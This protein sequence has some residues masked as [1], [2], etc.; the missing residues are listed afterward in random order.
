MVEVPQGFDLG[1]NSGLSY[2]YCTSREISIAQAMSDAQIHPRFLGK[3]M[4]TM[5][6][7]P[8]RVGGT[9]GP[10]YSDSDEITWEELGVTP[11]L[12]T[13]TKRVRR[14]ATFS[15]LQYERSLNAIVPDYVFLNFLNYIPPASQQIFINRLTKLRT[16]THVGTGP[17]VTDVY[18]WLLTG[19]IRL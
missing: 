19:G 14:V 17:K 16:P 1:I 9:S 4:M 8:I 7:Y 11:E 13:V 2:P 18:P 12:T 6:T 3:V 5:R 10:F 15:M